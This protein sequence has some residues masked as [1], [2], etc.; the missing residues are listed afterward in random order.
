[1]SKTKKYGPLSPLC[2]N[3]IRIFKTHFS[4]HGSDVYDLSWSA[5]SKHLLSGSTDNT[6]ILWHIPSGKEVQRMRD[7]GNYV[8]GVAYDPRGTYFATESCDRTLKVYSCKKDKQQQK[9]KENG[10]YHMLH[11]VNKREYDQIQQTVPNTTTT[12]ENPVQVIPY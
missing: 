8:Q 7:H 1:M 4:G 5:D 11:S 10:E 2:G 12:E 9:K 3:S 6:S